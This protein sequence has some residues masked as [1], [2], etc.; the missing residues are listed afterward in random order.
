MGIWRSSLALLIASALVATF[1]STAAAQTSIDYDDPYTGASVVRLTTDG[2][3]GCINYMGN[4]S[5][6]STAWSPDSSQIVFAKWCEESPAKTGI[7]VIDVATGQQGC[8]AAS[9]KHWAN[10][11]FD[12]DGDTVWF[13]DGS[14]GARDADGNKP[15]AVR[16]V[17]VPS[18]L[19]SQATCP[20]A[21]VMA[22][23]VQGLSPDRVD[24]IT[25]MT[26]NAPSATTTPL[27]SLFATQV[28]TG[29]QW[30]T[31]VFHAGGELLAGWDFDDATN[32]RHNDYNDGDAS[33]WSPVDPRLIFTNRGTSA[34]DD[35]VRRGVFTVTASPQLQYKPFPFS[36]EC[37]GDYE[38]PDSVA[39][40][41]WIWHPG[42]DTDVFMSND[43]CVWTIDADGAT[44]TGSWRV[45]GY[46][47]VYFD[48]SSIDGDLADVRV[49]VD[50]YFDGYGAEPFL[51]RATLGDLGVGVAG[52]GLG[53]WQTLRA[54]RKLVLHRNRMDDGTNDTLK[55]FEPHPQFSPDGRF[56][57]WQSSSLNDVLDFTCEA[58]SCGLPGKGNDSQTSFLDLYV[59]RQAQP[60]ADI[61]GDTTCDGV[62]TTDDAT[63]ILDYLVG[64]RGAATDC[65]SA[66]GSSISARS[67]KLTD[68]DAIGVDDALLL[69]RCL[70]DSDAEICLG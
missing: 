32:P 39:H 44:T 67:A 66:T 33:I 38:T 23:D 26:K 31:I 30:R 70:R 65:F 42:T 17:A 63:A 46:V 54:E 47:H 8:I 13:L 10:P 40:S 15:F 1:A 52:S 7:Y 24:D 28:R 45:F 64:S 69:A 4:Q 3:Q 37:S 25:V 5:G 18:S 60:P 2:P 35:T 19:D 34:S 61:A 29:S 27:E 6:E 51:Y 68:D 43:R 53:D 14:D 62:V 48:R 49:V 41:D 56:V 22:V 20:D 11:I 16:S 55:A 36:T 58:A 50:E 59:V 21:S 9:D 57:L 12:H